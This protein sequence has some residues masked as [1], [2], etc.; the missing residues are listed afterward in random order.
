MNLYERLNNIG[1]Y[2][3]AGLFENTDRSLFYRKALALRRYYENVTP[4][5][6]TGDYLYPPKAPDENFC[7]TVH[8]FEGTA[9]RDRKRLEE[10]DPEA[11]KEF[12]ESDF[13][14][15]H[16]AM[17]LPWQHTVGGC[18]YIHSMPA[19]DRIMREGLDSYLVRVK[20]MKDEDMRDGLLHV[21]CGIRTY[22][23]KCLDYL[24]KTNAR[25]ELIAALEKVPFAPCETIYEA[26]V[27]RNF[28]FML[29]IDNIGTV[30]TDLYPYYKGEDMTEV[31]KELYGNI[32]NNEVWS[33]SL[34]P[35]HN[36]VTLQC[37]EGLKGARRPMTE[38]II[39]E[40][41]CSDDVWTAALEAMRTSSG[42]PAFYNYRLIEKLGERF[43]EIRKE[44]LNKFCG[45]G[46]TESMLQGLCNVGSLD[47]GVNLLYIFEGTMKDYLEKASDFEDFYAK[48][49]EDVRKVVD[50]ITE[51]ISL[52]RE[53]RAKYQPH[54]MRTLLTD[55]CI[56]KERDFNNG[57]P[58]YSWSIITFAA[59][60]NVIDSLIIL[61]DLVFDGNKKKY[62]PS[63]LLALLAENDENFLTEAKNYPTVFGKDIPEV[64]ELSARL[65]SEVYSMLDGKKPFR[66]LGYLPAHILFNAAPWAGS[67]V[68]ATPD[69]RK[70]G[71]PIAESLGAAMGKDT[72]GPTALL[73][74]VTSMTLCKALG[75]PVLNFTVDPKFENGVI[76]TLIETYFE[77]GGMQ[78]QVTCV[79]R[80]T[81]ED[82]Y[83]H[84][85]QY[86]N[87]V[88]R[89]AGYSE[90]FCRLSDEL[91]RLVIERTIY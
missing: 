9:V 68:G 1:E 91:K 35:D 48:Y 13:F 44:D 59:V 42:N 90:Y 22:H 85:E 88:I 25:P 19:Y 80:K 54:P 3:A 55:D 83:A 63:E 24:R 18:M 30:A 32:D 45:G 67:Y 58:R 89:I 78:M 61:R 29:D 82:A 87:L 38:L 28:V 51:K 11:A 5:A 79:S 52:S 27:C 81:L 57:G 72:E 34:G 23:A 26:L 66:G 71:A 53:T 14:K 69:G 36:P 56:E 6:H 39:K 10:S 17:Y 20:N 62:S 21:L 47:A 43:P 84:P 7:V 37:L 86:K 75:T 73:N 41:N 46:C 2:Y 77:H 74:S 65:T 64:N 16:P 49:I 33:M 15:Y 8:F 50:D 31:I 12:F 60:V 76:R 4:P 40:G 70:S